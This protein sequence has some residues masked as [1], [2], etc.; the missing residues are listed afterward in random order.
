M[1]IDIYMSCPVCLQEGY[2]TSKQ[3]W[4]HSWPCG[5]RLTLDDKARIKCAKCRRG[6]HILG[7][8]LKCSEGRHKFKVCSQEGYAAAISTSSH[9]VNG[10]GMSWLQSVISNI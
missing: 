10:G 6:G 3:Y 5:G 1:K 2:N 8:K 9:F 4:K 7:M